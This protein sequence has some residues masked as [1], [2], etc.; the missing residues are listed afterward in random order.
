MNQNSFY[1][2][3]LKFESNMKLLTQIQDNQQEK[4]QPRQ[5]QTMLTQT[6]FKSSEKDDNRKNLDVMIQENME[7][8]EKTTPLKVSP[9]KTSS[10]TTAE[11]QEMTVVVDLASQPTRKDIK[12]TSLKL[13]MDLLHQ[14]NPV[15]FV[16]MGQKYTQTFASIQSSRKNSFSIMMEDVATDVDTPDKNV[17]EGNDDVKTKSTS[18]VVNPYAKRDPTVDS[19]T[20]ADEQIT[21]ETSDIDK[22]HT[23]VANADDSDVSYSSSSKSSKT[24]NKKS[25]TQSNYCCYTQNV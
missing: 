22:Q 21:L 25:A 15:P 17:V 10:T 19:S 2:K 14:K 7:S 1:V 16:S 20:T 5:I 11:G 12:G 24:T 3:R 6:I 23:A 13:M 18:T 8:F 9:K 4:R